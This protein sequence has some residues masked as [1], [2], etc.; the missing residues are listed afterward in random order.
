MGRLLEQR[1]DAGEDCLGVPLDVA[2]AE[3]QTSAQAVEGTSQVA[4]LQV[5]HHSD[6]FACCYFQSVHFPGRENRIH[7]LTPFPLLLVASFL[8]APRTLADLI[9]AIAAIRIGHHNAG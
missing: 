9:D 4:D 2:V 5:G 8:P 7:V 1:L 6:P 3:R